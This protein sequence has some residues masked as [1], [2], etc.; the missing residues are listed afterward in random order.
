[1]NKV[2]KGFFILL[3]SFTLVGCSQSVHE[4]LQENQ[5]NVTST[6]GSLYTA[7]F[8]ETTV[9]FEQGIFQ[10]G[11]AYTIKDDQLI[12]TDPRN[13]EVIFYEIKEEGDEIKLIPVEEKYGILILSVDKN[14]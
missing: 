14:E 11:M 9:S 10:T 12:M 2:Y 5:W 13:E 4:Q 7:N 8:S 3:F 1:M 6:S